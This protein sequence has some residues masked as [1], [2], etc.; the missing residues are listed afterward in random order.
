MLTLRWQKFPIRDILQTDYASRAV[1]VSMMS[2]VQVQ[3]VWNTLT[4]LK[5]LSEVSGRPRP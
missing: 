1:Y 3:Y 4:R 5:H 2:I